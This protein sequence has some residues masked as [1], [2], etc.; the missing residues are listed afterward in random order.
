[1]I[2]EYVQISMIIEKYHSELA[3]S[4][5]YCEFDHSWKNIHLLLSKTVIIL[6]D[7]FN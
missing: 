5:S 6:Q 7:K 1:M 4:I 3:I 2:D